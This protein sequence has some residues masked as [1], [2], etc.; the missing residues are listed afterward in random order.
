MP[1]EVGDDEIID[2]I[3][4]CQPLAGRPITLITYDTHMST[5]ARAH[6]IPVISQN[7][8]SRRSRRSPASRPEHE[9]PAAR[10]AGPLLCSEVGGSPGATVLPDGGP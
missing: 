1:L 9:G 4:A 3:L 8:P 6:G 7:S 2:R 10:A 5:K